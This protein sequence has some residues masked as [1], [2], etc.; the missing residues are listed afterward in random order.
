M[1]H[2][3]K[4]QKIYRQFAAELV[5]QDS[6]LRGIKEI[7]HDLDHAIPN[8]LCDILLGPVKLWC[9]QHMMERDAYKLDKK[10]ASRTSKEKIMTDIYGSQVDSILQ[11]GLA[12]VMNE[13]D[14]QV[15][16][17]SLK[18]SWD[19]LVPG[20]HEWF[21]KNCERLFCNSLIMSAREKLGMKG[22]FY[23]NDLELKYKLQKKQMAEENIPKGVAA[24]TAKL[25]NWIEDFHEEEVRALRGLGKYRLSA[26]C[27]TFFVDPC[28]WNT[29][30]V[31]RQNSHVKKYAQFNPRSYDTYRK[32][33]LASLKKAPK[34]RR[35]REPEADLF[36]D[37]LVESIPKKVIKQSCHKASTQEKN[38]T[39][40][41]LKR[42]IVRTANWTVRNI[43]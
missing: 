29:W 12:H 7:G 38:V 25:Q 24:V 5:M 37:R 1:W 8:G 32:L 9:T 31:E 27:E 26:G 39:P 33:V 30:S 11:L 16:L 36:V 17:D 10:H 13:E 40:I 41:R 23:T 20:F 2:F 19:N 35:A 18:E 3:H 15:K 6:A 28:K 4:D 14:F 22:R 21:H 43:F 34:K 42:P